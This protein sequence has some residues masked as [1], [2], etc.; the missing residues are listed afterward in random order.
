VLAWL[1][2]ALGCGGGTTQSPDGGERQLDV[3]AEAH[4]DSA[5]ICAGD[6]ATPTHAATVVVRN[7]RTEAIY[8]K[9]QVSVV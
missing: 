2:S 5:R 7:D 3:S 1:P 6:E 4:Q 8:V 9:Q